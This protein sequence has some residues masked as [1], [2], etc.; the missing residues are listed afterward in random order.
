LAQRVD[1]IVPALRR[2][3][4]ELDRR[5]VA[6]D[7]LHAQGLR[8]REDRLKAVEVGLAR[9]VIVG[10]A[11]AADERTGLARLE[12][13]RA[14]AHHVLLVPALVLVEDRLGVDEIVRRRQ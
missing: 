10:I 3:A 8:L 12:D 4:A 6:A 14:G 13:E 11:L 2:E 5:L 7:R 9:N 1:E